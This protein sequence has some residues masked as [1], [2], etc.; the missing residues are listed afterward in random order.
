VIAGISRFPEQALNAIQ[1][2]WQLFGL[3]KS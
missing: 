2:A 1:A 3:P